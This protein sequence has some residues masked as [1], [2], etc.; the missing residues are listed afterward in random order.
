MRTAAKQDVSQRAIVDALEHVGMTVQSLRSVG[1]GCP[2]LLVAWRGVNCLIEVKNPLGNGEGLATSLNQQEQDWHLTW[3][4][5][6]A[7]VRTPEEAVQA[8][9]DHARACGVNV[10]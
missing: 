9:I 10:G 3:A 5:Q 6:C 4:G 1:S 8:V 7:V 2:D